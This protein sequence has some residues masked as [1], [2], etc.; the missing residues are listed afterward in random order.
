MIELTPEQ[1]AAA[2][3]ALEAKE[4][5]TKAQVIKVKP[6][7][8]ERNSN[9][10]TPCVVDAP[11]VDI[12]EAKSKKTAPASCENTLTVLYRNLRRLILG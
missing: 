7:A 2:L 1:D 4:A 8:I 12:A 11:V 5:C 6:G 3:A 10:E 9:P